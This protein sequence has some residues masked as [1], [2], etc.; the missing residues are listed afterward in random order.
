[1]VST[2]YIQFPPT[3]GN[4][5]A[6]VVA[7]FSQFLCFEGM[8]PEKRLSSRM[9]FFAEHSFGNGHADPAEVDRTLFY[10]NASAKN[11][12][13]RD[14]LG[15]NK[16]TLLVKEKG[17]RFW[18]SGF[19][20]CHKSE[21]RDM[22]KLQQ[23]ARHYLEKAF[24]GQDKALPISEEKNNDLKKK[25]EENEAEK[26]DLDK[27]LKESKVAKKEH[28]KTLDALTAAEKHQQRE[29]QMNEIL[30][31]LEQSESE[32]KELE[33]IEEAQAKELKK[34][35]EQIEA[36]KKDLEQHEIKIKQLEMVN[37][38]HR[39]ATENLLKQK[40]ENE[41]L[42]K[43][44]TELEDQKDQAAED[45]GEIRIKLK[46]KEEE[47]ANVEALNNTL[48]VKELKSNTELQEARTE[49]IRG[50]ESASRAFIRLKRMGGLDCRPFQTACKRKYPTEEIN[51]QAAALCS[52]WES[53]IGD[54]S[55][56]P[57]KVSTASFGHNKEIINEEDEKM[58]KLK[59]E[60]GVEVHLAVSTAL[61]ELN[62]YN[63][64]GRYPL[65]ELWNF[66]ED[67]RASLKEAILHIMKQLKQKKKRRTY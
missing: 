6:W 59:N 50:W 16:E 22:G 63:P 31:K 42:R 62:E 49:L 26:K 39:K 4:G 27:K 41:E 58:K 67:R 21:E 1:M 30:K 13:I 48:I 5:F 38:D 53:Y 18:I 9:K 61:L 28:E 66:K 20:M 32:K 54:P 45:S 11:A 14:S 51:V 47:L 3:A 24:L 36:Q 17:D 23:N 57:F 7:V 10:E 46:E 2:L 25:L 15:R 44:I 33:K 29:T 12:N 37:L 64:S 65:N 8:A 52:L 60:F 56:H 40:K 34:A 43:R 55:W 19:K 35:L